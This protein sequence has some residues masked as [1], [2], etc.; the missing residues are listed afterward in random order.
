MTGAAGMAKDPIF[1]VGHSNHSLDGFLALLS[2]H[3]VTAVVDVRSAPYSRF[4]PHFNRDALATALEDRNIGYA[5]LGR[6]LGGRPDDP[7]CYEEGR[8]SYERIARTARFRSGLARVAETAA[9]GRV[10][11]M[12]AE[13]E[14]LDCHRTLLV[15]R[16]L[17][18]DGTRVVHILPDGSEEPHAETMERLMTM[19]GLNPG[20]DL[21]RSPDELIAE[22]IKRRARR[23]AFAGAGPAM[24]ERQAR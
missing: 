11:L 15:A 14:P 23:V 2:K 10:A 1:T 12:C 21:F 7:A 3:R 18:V 19:V 20:G 16:V 8:V 24:K 22:A 4:R 5:Y 9:R 6:E 13:K 17:D